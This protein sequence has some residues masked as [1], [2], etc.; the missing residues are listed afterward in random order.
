[1]TE[2]QWF[3]F[4]VLPIMIGIA[5]TVISEIVVRMNRR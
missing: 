5:G 1:M 4:I 3:A 2:E